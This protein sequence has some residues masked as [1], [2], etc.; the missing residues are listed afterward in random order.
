MKNKLLILLFVFTLQTSFAGYKDG[1]S[2]VRAYT[3]YGLNY[4]YFLKPQTILDFDLLTRY[5]FGELGACFAGYYGKS[6]TLW[7]NEIEKTGIN[8]FYTAGLHIGYYREWDRDPLERNFIFGPSLRSGLE[9]TVRKYLAVGSYIRPYYSV[10]HTSDVHK[11]FG[12]LD[13][14]LYVKVII[15]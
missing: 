15:K 4:N 5:E 3:G 10:I 1:I 9:Y 8:F 7:N 11:P 13:G 6:K 14:G 12:Y 2:V